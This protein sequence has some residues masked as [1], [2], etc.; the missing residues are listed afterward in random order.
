M[1]DALGWIATALTVSSYFT[2]QPTT[3]RRV[4]AFAACLW[5]TYGVLIH[6]SPI[7][8]ANMIVAGVAIATSLRGRATERKPVAAAE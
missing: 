8:A 3:L 4:Q 5:A 1:L 2:R 6:A 7:I